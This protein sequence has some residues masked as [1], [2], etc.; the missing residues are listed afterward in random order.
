M[1]NSTGHQN[2]QDL[3]MGTFVFDALGQR[4]AGELCQ[5]QYL[6]DGYFGG[7]DQ[8]SLRWDYYRTRTEG[9]NCLVLNQQNVAVGQVSPITTATTG[10][11][12]NGLTQPVPS[13][14]TA[15]YIGDMT[16]SYNGTSIKRGMRYING[17]TQ[18]LLQDEITG[19]G[20]NVQWRMHTNATID[21]SNNSKTATLTL[22]GEKLVAQLLQDGTWGTAQPVRYSTDPPLP[23]GAINQDL[24]NT[25]VTVLTIDVNPGTWTLSVLFNPQYEGWS[26][27]SFK[28]PPNVPLAQWSLTSHP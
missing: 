14:S 18:L 16:T 4:W 8:N 7:E 21:I 12:Q 15:F 1:G 24:P 19:S 13:S 26:S 3:D 22:G 23:A 2:H 25:G 9:Q 17:R 11:S 6:A 20:A 10:E 5:A 28:T 27:S